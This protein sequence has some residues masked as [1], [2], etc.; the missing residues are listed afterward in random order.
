LVSVSEQRLFTL[1]PD[2][3]VSRE[4]EALLR[5][6][7]ALL[8]KWTVRINLISNSGLIDVWARHILDSAQLFRFAPAGPVH[9]ADVGSGGG[10]PGIVICIL[11]KESP[12]PFR[13]TLVESDQRKA[14]FLR[15]AAHE[16]G[17][18]P[19]ILSSRI[20][21]MPPLHVDVLSARALGPLSALLGYAER[22]LSRT[23]MAV[24]PKGRTA[25]AE[26]EAARQSWHFDLAASASMTDP[27][28]QIL[29]IQ[30]ISHV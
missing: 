7:V 19:R 12:H 3:N 16:L 26:I 8:G 23:G 30:N 14:A 4:T 2:L 22:H 24:F 15:V 17:L 27:E 21:D 29:R 13:V 10:F 11:A 25:P 9:W 1:L 6:F 18:A 5:Q 28:A 20:E